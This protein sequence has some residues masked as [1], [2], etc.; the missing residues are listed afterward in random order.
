MGILTLA[1][2]TVWVSREQH[3]QDA[4]EDTGESTWN[5]ASYAKIGA[6]STAGG[7]LAGAISTS[8]PPADLEAAS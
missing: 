8:F 6:V 4:T 2:S 3:S 5:F 1:L 7:L